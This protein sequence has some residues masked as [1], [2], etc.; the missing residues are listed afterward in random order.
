[1]MRPALEYRKEGAMKLSL[2]RCHT[3][4]CVSESQEVFRGRSRGV[5]RSAK[6]NAVK[7]G[8]RP[9]N[10]KVTPYSILTGYD[11]FYEFGTDKEQPARTSR[12]KIPVG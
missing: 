4:A 10:E 2:V 12:S 9:G 7:T 5:G 1:M 8:Y 11:N 6:L 3:Q